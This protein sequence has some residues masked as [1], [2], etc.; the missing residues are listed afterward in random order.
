MKTKFFAALQIVALLFA[1]CSDTSETEG[2]ILGEAADS[3]DE[4]NEPI[5]TRA[6]TIYVSNT[7]T[8]Y[9]KDTLVLRQIDTISK[10]DTLRVSHVD[11]VVVS[12][13]DTLHVSQVDT[14]VVSKQDTLH[15]SRVDTLVISKQDTLHISQVDTLVI[16]KQ[17][18]LH[19]S[20]V[21]TLVISKQDT[22]HVSH[23]DTVVIDNT[24]TS[25]TGILDFNPPSLII[26]IMENLVHQ[27]RTGDYKLQQKQIVLLHF[28][29][30]HGD[31]ENLKRIKEFKDAYSEYIDEVVHTGDALYEVW[32]DSFD[33]WSRAGADEFLNTL[34]NHDVKFFDQSWDPVEVSI[35]EVYNRY[36]APFIDSWNVV[37]PENAEENALMY[38]YKDIDKGS[39]RERAKLRLIVLDEYH[40]DSAQADWLVSVLEDAR[41]NDFAVIICR[42]NGFDAIP[43][44][45]NPF[46]SLEHIGSA[47]SLQEAQVAVDEFMQNGGE[48]V[49]WLGGH[50]HQDAVG[51]LPNYPKQIIFLGDQ[52]SMNWTGWND[53]WRE[54]G[55]KS[56]DCFTLI[57]VDR[58]EKIVRFV[59]I[60]ADRDR[61][62]R[63][64]ESMSINYG[65]SEALFPAE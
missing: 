31:E 51:R 12:K 30:I 64:K 9:I 43:L 1:G 33:F 6:D 65:T 24:A 10:Q 58:Y 32:T 20:Q 23:I 27:K 47:T 39:G 26:P 48:F 54:S 44:N 28:T 61:Y 13:Q 15:I 38:Y 59:R 62:E 35:Q 21:D 8:L 45:N 2:L 36:F 7:D 14:V 19:V 3:G 17:D 37:Q 34:G 11:T 52:A 60:G 53:S 25:G 63:P 29:D 46:T 41:V 55:T 16:S 40:W 4:I 5:S 56:Q 50:G 22:L 18:T 57:G 42:H 49:V